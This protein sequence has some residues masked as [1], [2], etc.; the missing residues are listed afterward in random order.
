MNI[1]FDLVQGAFWSLTYILVIVHNFKYRT[2]GLPP[3][4]MTVNFAWET[5]A[6]LR[7]G[8]VVHRIWFGLDFLIIVSYYIRCG[9]VYYKFKCFMPLLFAGLLAVFA[10][11]FNAGGMLVSSFVIDLTMAIEYF[12]FILSLRKKSGW[13]PTSI[14]LLAICATKLLGDQAAWLYYM[15]LSRVA[16]VIGILVFLLNTCCL[17]VALIRKNPAAS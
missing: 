11:V 15:E 16:S 17:A 5:I 12:V 9:C 7:F 13:K 8:T 14:L 2:S 1:N 10:A 4:A 6:L 3:I